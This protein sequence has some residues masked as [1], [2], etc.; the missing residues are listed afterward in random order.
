[1]SEHETNRW[2]GVG[3]TALLAGAVGLLSAR[4]SLLLVGVVGVV[5]AVYP[6]VFSPPTPDLKLDRR[7]D[8]PTPNFG[9]AVRV[10]VSLTNVGSKPLFDLRVVDGVPASLVVTD[11][12]PRCGTALRPGETQQFVYSVEATHG[13]HTFEPTIVVARDPSGAYEVETSVVEETELVCRALPADAHLRRHTI[14]CIGKIATNRGGQGIEFHSSRDYRH[15]DPLSQFDWKRYARTREETTIEYRVEQSARLVLLVDARRVAYRAPPNRPHGVAYS[16]AAAE[17]L[18]E[19]LLDAHN[20]V[21]LAALGCDDCWLEPGRG[22]QHRVRARR[23]LITHETFSAMPHD[24]DDEPALDEQVDTLL[25]RLGATT[26]VILL[27]PMCDPEITR[28]ARIF[29]VYG[30][31]VTVI[32]PD[33]TSDETLGQRLAAMDRQNC[34]AALRSV[35]IPVVE[36]RPSTPLATALS[37]SATEVQP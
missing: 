13:T 36:W 4:P 19:G 22:P 7:V 33:V 9:E 17:D 35:G 3:G 10:T 37:A 23:H 26:Q 32:S 1:M 18:L 11:G 21:G 14:E 16:V 28:V 8:N 34:I 25:G 27:T 12:S 29:E 20:D 2:R 5:F 30:H 15:G 31:H 6:R 24:P